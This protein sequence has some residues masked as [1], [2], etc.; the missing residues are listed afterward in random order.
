MNPYDFVRI[1]WSK[2]IERRPY[3]PHDSFSGLSG[4]IQGTITTLTPFFIPDRKN[5]SPKQFLTNRH[6]QAIIPGSSLKGLIRSLVETIGPGCWWLFDGTYESN[7]VHYESKLPHEFR[8]CSDEKHLCVACR[9][10]GMIHGKTN[11][12]LLGHVGFDDAVCDAPRPHESIHTIILSSPK[13]HHAAFY[14]DEHGELAG[15]KFYFHHNTPPV[16]KEDWLPKGKATSQHDAQNQY[17]KPIDAGSVFT[18]S[19]HFGNLAQDELDLLLY[20]LVLEPGMRH[21]LGYAKPAGLG[22][23]EIALTRL[24]LVDYSQRYTSPDG[25]RTVYA[26]AALEAYVDGQI[27]PYVNDT[28]SITLQDL[29]RIWRWP[30]YE[31]ISYPSY[32]WFKTNYD[33]RLHEVP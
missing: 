19:A 12:L 20:A 4:H 24:E 14:L 8:Q 15:R 22:S 5:R 25:G 30:G 33:K 29:R 26:G 9:M 16:D 18:F 17:I 1:D 32:G 3:T 10:F 7:K 11:T 21:K 13:P 28:D 6:G 27:A 23:V 2:G 31:G